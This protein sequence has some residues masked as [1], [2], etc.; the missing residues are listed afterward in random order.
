MSQKILED[1]STKEVQ[2]MPIIDAKNPNR[3]HTEK[4]DK[5]LRELVTC[6][7]VNLENPGMILKFPYGST[8]N[9]KT[10]T[11]I[12]GGVYKVPRFLSRHI[13]SRAEP[14]WGWRPD[15]S[16]SIQKELQGDKPRFNM[17]EVYV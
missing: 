1:Y 14:R 2:S 10:F 13:D 5:W 7:F 15:G 11:F 8:R 6:E 4:E 17:R 12:H 16:G 9:N 3:K